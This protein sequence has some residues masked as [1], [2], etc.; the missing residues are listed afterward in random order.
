MAFTLRIMMDQVYMAFMSIN[1]CMKP[2]GTIV[3]LSKIKLT[4]T[5]T[6]IL[7]NVIL[8]VCAWSFIYMYVVLF[9]Y[10]GKVYANFGQRLFYCVNV[11]INYFHQ[12][13]LYS[14]LSI[15]SL[16]CRYQCVFPLQGLPL[17]VCFLQCS[18]GPHSQFPV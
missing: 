1:L 13:T 12:K 8:C 15:T 11:F 3:R 7:I 2:L 18:Q 14:L 4:K 17:V 10:H 5:I 6:W 9:I 16:P